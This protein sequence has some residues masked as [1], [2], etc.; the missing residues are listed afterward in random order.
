VATARDR[1]VHTAIPQTRT[2]RWRQ[3]RTGFDMRLIKKVHLC[4]SV[5]TIPI[6]LSLAPDTEILKVV[7]GPKR[8]WREN[9][10]IERLTVWV[11]FG[12]IVTLTPFIFSF[13]QSVGG[14]HG[15]SFDSILGSG[16][17]L[18][19]GVAIAAGAFGELIV[20]D[21]TGDQRLFRTLAIGSCSIVIIVS[22]LWF[23]GISAAIA[24]KAAPDPQV[25]SIGSVLVYVWALISSAWCL[26]L[27]AS[28]EST[29]EKSASSERTTPSQRETLRRDE[30]RS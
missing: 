3:H 10:V 1:D 27:A 12:V 26:S 4:C 29:I 16:Q 5:D 9:P 23:G 13:L 18:L 25:I 20:I 11:I 17:L 19:V 7:T 30:E 6:T 24:E 15:L 8:K 14:K 2:T 22:S 28:N 21:V